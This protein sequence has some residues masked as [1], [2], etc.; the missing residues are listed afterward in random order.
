MKCALCQ[1]KLSSPYH[2]WDLKPAH[3]RCVIEKLMELTRPPARTGTA[4]V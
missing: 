3:L 2:W 4:S 1:E